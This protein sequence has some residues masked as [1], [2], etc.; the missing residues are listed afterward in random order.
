MSVAH[1]K[2]NLIS[3]SIGLSQIEFE[4][5]DNL[6]KKILVHLEEKKKKLP[7]KNK[8]EAEASVRNVVSGKKREITK[9]L[10]HMALESEF[11][12]IKNKIDI[13]WGEKKVIKKFI[14]NTMERMYVVT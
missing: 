9:E 14:E 10:F 12:Q 6:A 7:F 4:L 13:K 8:V 3:K 5:S 1:K 2:R 11:E